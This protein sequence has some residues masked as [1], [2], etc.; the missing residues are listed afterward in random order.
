MPGPSELLLAGPVLM[1]MFGVLKLSYKVRYLLDF[2][3]LYCYLVPEY[4][5]K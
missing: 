2:S 5:E 1:L 4:E 3:K